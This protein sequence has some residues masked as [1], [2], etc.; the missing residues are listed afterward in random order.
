MG[1]EIGF[2]T[3]LTY[4][5][6]TDMAVGF[7]EDGGTTYIVIARQRVGAKRRPMTGSA[8]QSII[9]SQRER[10]DCFVA[11]APRNDGEPSQDW[12][13]SRKYGSTA[14]WTLMVRGLP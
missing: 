13:L 7:R 11:G 9:A 14:P 8:K 1:E 4:T 3:S 2:V 6:R 12:P 5:I 10:L